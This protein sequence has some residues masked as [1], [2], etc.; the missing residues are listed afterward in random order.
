MAQTVLQNF[1]FKLPHDSLSDEADRIQSDP[2]FV[3]VKSRREKLSQA[4]LDYVGY[5]RDKQ[6]KGEFPAAA[7]KS[8]QDIQQQI[9]I[10]R[11]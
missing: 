4:W 5:T 11:K 9:D 2:I 8:A 3:L 1:K 10:M 6:V 7:E